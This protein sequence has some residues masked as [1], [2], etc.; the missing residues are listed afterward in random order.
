MVLN[1]PLTYV[2]LQNNI[3]QPK[4]ILVRVFQCKLLNIWCLLGENI[5]D[6]DL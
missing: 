1:Y 3:K 6:T 4:R 5:N 2:I